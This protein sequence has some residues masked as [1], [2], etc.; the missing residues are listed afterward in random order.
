MIEYGCFQALLM[1]LIALHP[2]QQDVLLGG[3]VPQ[4]TQLAHMG[5]STQTEIL[6]VL[7][8]TPTAVA[9]KKVMVSLHVVQYVA[10]A[11]KMR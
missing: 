10:T 4:E 2:A 1:C 9:E 3:L 5:T 8:P 11:A 7:P 6:A